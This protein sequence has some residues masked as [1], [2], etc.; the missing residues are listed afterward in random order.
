MGFILREVASVCRDSG[1]QW[2][3]VQCLGC[4]FIM[5]L[6]LERSLLPH[7]TGWRLGAANLWL[8]AL[9]ML[10]FARY[11]LA[12]ETASQST[13]VPIFFASVIFG[14]GISVWARWRSDEFERRVIFLNIL[15]VCFLA[16]AA[17]WQPKTTLEFQYHNTPRWSGIWD[18]PNLYGLLMGTGL[19][20]AFGLLLHNSQ[21]TKFQKLWI[22]FCAVSMA[23]TGDGL[24][25][26]YSRG[27]WLGTIC[28]LVYLVSGFWIRDSQ[29]SHISW[30]KRNCI[31]VPVTLI[32]IF[33]LALAQF[34]KPYHPVAKR[35]FSAVNVNDFSWRNRFAALEVTL[36]IIAEHPWLGA[37]WNQPEPLYEHYYLPSKLDESAAIEM[38]DYLMLSATLGIPALF[39]FGMYLWL[40]QGKNFG[41][42]GQETEL[43]ALDWLPKICHAGAI[44]L[45]VGFWFD[46]GL[47]KL[48]TASTFWILLELG[49]AQSHHETD[50]L[51]Q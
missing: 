47:F 8:G 24:L 48:A 36:Q 41:A 3:L 39:C 21:F 43:A 35:V 46:G 19:T 38:D 49:A 29:L 7:N 40:S 15:L 34:Q 13:Q 2:I 6:I 5:L 4:Y 44:V 32:F 22:L 11:E 28:G 37:G 14:K 26:S 20:L 16:G 31:L 10:A 50:N 9:V 25:K 27:A 1:M 17:L 18:N 12:S 30:L 33:I 45:L 23:L 42:S 51:R